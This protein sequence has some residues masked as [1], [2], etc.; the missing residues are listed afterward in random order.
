MFVS[1][2]CRRQKAGTE[3][4]PSGYEGVPGDTLNIHFTDEI[5]SFSYVGAVVCQTSGNRSG[6]TRIACGAASRNSTYILVILLLCLPQ[7]HHSG[8]TCS[9]ILCKQFTGIL[10][11][12]M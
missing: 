5:S 9:K 8:A 10:E 7:G 2:Q 12:S 3:I 4:F 6:G 1:P 11:A